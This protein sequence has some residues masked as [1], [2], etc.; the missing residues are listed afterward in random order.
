MS[1][2]WAFRLEPVVRRNLYKDFVQET[3]NRAEVEL[4]IAKF[5]A[6]T[7]LQKREWIHLPI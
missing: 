3:N 5:R 7:Q 1:L 2:Y 6:L 4:A